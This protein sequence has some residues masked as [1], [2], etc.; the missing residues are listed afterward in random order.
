MQRRR[1]SSAP[2]SFANLY[3]K[4]NYRN[5][6]LR[7]INVEISYKKLDKKRKSLQHAH[8]T[9]KP[10]TRLKLLV[11]F[12]SKLR[13]PGNRSWR[14]QIVWINPTFQFRAYRWFLNSRRFHSNIKTKNQSNTN[15][16]YFL[17][18]I[19]FTPKYFGLNKTSE[20][21]KIYYHIQENLIHFEIIQ[22]ITHH[23]SRSIISSLT[24]TIFST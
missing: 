10:C 19:C 13:D 21:L 17:I 2:G 15:C 18:L 11:T 3:L 4:N 12:C 9:S 1:T 16:F 23:N 7:I 8:N 14:R 20:K 5:N 24:P 6:Q 22:K